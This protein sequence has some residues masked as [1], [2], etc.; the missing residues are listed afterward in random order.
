MV[1]FKQFISSCLIGSLA[2][3]GLGTSLLADSTRSSTAAWDGTNILI[4]PNISSGKIKAAYWTTDAAIVATIAATGWGLY[5]SRIHKLSRIYKTVGEAA[6][7]T[8]ALDSYSIFNVVVDPATGSKKITGLS[9]DFSV[10]LTGVGKLNQESL[11]SIKKILEKDLTLDKKLDEILKIDGCS[12]ALTEITKSTEVSEELKQLAQALDYRRIIGE[13]IDRFILEQF[14]QDLAS[15]IS[16]LTLVEKIEKLKS[17]RIDFLA[18]RVAPDTLK[19]FGINERVIITNSELMD[20]VEVSFCSGSYELTLQQAVLKQLRSL[21]KVKPEFVDKLITKISELYEEASF[22]NK[23]ITGSGKELAGVL[24]PEITKEELEVL[25]QSELVK[26]ILGLEKEQEVSTESIKAL[27]TKVFK[28]EGETKLVGEIGSK[29]L[30]LEDIC[31]AIGIVVVSDTKLSSL[32]TTFVRSGLVGGLAHTLNT[33]K[34][35]RSMEVE[36]TSKIVRSGE[37]EALSIAG[38]TAKNITYW[39]Y[40]KYFTIGAIGLGAVSF[41]SYTLGD[42]GK[43]QALNDEAQME[44]NKIF[45]GVSSLAQVQNETDGLN[46]LVKKMFENLSYKCAGSGLE[47]KLSNNSSD[48]TLAE[49]QLLEEEY[50]TMFQGKLIDLVIQSLGDD[51]QDKGLSLKDQIVCT[52]KDGFS[53][54]YKV[55]VTTRIYDS[56]SNVSNVTNELPIGV[57]ISADLIDTLVDQSRTSDGSDRN[58]FNAFSVEANEQAESLVSFLNNKELQDKVLEEILEQSSEDVDEDELS[59]KIQD[60]FENLSN[61][62]KDS[63]NKKELYKLSFDKAIKVQ[64]EEENKNLSTSQFTGKEK[65]YSRAYDLSK[66]YFDNLLIQEI[67]PENTTEI[68]TAMESVDKI[69]DNTFEFNTDDIN[70]MVVEGVIYYICHPEEL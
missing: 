31:K 4:N 17:G 8:K 63:T 38:R 11:S 34:A 59:Q 43:Q 45:K 9:E 61:T 57:F 46:W 35:L 13:K 7:Y 53:V 66:L 16:G 64:I 15:E 69:L 12:E 18:S 51:F 54:G 5:Q 44:A 65:E 19:L 55:N 14:G 27:L 23:E 21:D 2:L 29:A 24:F 49:I 6:L 48:L 60:I 40:V 67:N 50:K 37:S 20:L 30:S 39:K 28:A 33:Y 3:S 41:A 10:A 62:V 42:W 47:G 26:Q 52:S 70:T 1:F 22:L 36:Q 58:S 25:K 68:N 32:E 56:N